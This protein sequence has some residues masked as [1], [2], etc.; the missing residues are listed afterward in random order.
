MRSSYSKG[1]FRFVCR[2]TGIKIVKP[3]YDTV[4]PTRLRIAFRHVGYRNRLILPHKASGLGVIKEIPDIKAGK[5]ELIFIF[6][7][8]GGGLI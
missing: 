6:V 8:D 2:T 7:A 5:H 1:G 3:E 4:C